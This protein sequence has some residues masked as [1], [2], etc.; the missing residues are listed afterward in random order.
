MTAARI[1]LLAGAIGLAYLIAYLAMIGDLSL[2]RVDD[3]SARLATRWSELWL[4]P[5]GLFQFEAIAMLQ[6]GRVLFLVSP[7]NLL[8]AGVMAGLVTTNAHGIIEIRRMPAQCR[9]RGSS[10]GIFA[11]LPALVA[12]GACCA[13]ALIILLGIPGLGAFAGLF[14]WLIP[15]AIVLLVASRWWQLRLGAPAFLHAGEPG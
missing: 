14:G 11:S 9:P 8:L 15:V 7:L 10:G 4:Q 3:W 12:G 13:P 6:A 5:R 2:A 1:R